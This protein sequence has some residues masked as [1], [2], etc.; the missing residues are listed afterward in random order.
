MSKK[1]KKRKRARGKINLLLKLSIK[2]TCLDVRHYL[3]YTSYVFVNHI[4]GMMKSQ[5]LNMQH[6]R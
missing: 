1:Q 3:E 5:K 2:R 4:Q 6:W